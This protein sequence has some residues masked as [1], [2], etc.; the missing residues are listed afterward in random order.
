MFS[1]MQ[2]ASNTAGNS[3]LV[4]MQMSELQKGIPDIKQEMLAFVH[5]TLGT[6]Y[7]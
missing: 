7:S 1:L 6:M 4:S 3:F 2:S 5:A